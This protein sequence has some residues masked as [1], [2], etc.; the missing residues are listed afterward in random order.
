MKTKRSGKP[1]F[2]LKMAANLGTQWSIPDR[3]LIGMW[4]PT[5]WCGSEIYLHI[6]KKQVGQAVKDFSWDTSPL[7]SRNSLLKIKLLVAFPH[8][9]TIHKVAQK[10]PETTRNTFVIANILAFAPSCMAVTWQEKQV[11]TETVFLVT[12]ITTFYRRYKIITR[13]RS[14]LRHCATS[15]KVVG[16]IP[17]GVIGIFHWHYPSGRTMALRLT[18]PLTETSTRNSIC[19]T[20]LPS[21]SVDCLEIWEP[22]PPGTLWACPGM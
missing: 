20:I 11:P 7:N 8:Y 21:S 6:I 4:L 5:G 18:Q 10:S 3:L 13:W 14:W 19:L 9:I 1:F 12:S 2:V 22:Q 17:D 16:S 15:R